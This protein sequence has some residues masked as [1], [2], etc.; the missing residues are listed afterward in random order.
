MSIN[1]KES[2]I[3]SAIGNGTQRF[4]D[5]QRRR[6]IDV[7][8]DPSAAQCFWDRHWNQ[9]A[10]DQ[11]LAEIRSPN[12]MVLRVTQRYLK[13]G[14][15]ILEGGCGLGQ[16]VWGLEKAGYSVWGVDNAIQTLEMVRELEP[17]LKLSYGDV[18]ELDFP[19]ASF[20][21]YWS[22]G[23]IEHFWSGYDQILTEMARVLK[24]GGY[25]FITFPAMNPS[26]IARSARGYYPAWD[27]ET[28]SRLVEHFY[29]FILP[30]K[31]VENVLHTLGFT[32]EVVRYLDGYK[33]AKDEFA[34]VRRASKIA[35]L[36]GIG[37][38]WQK[39][40]NVVASNRYGHIALLV[41]RKE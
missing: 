33:G 28:G 6:L 7:H 39:L 8:R 21:G 4:F 40:M 19:D 34:T 17:G 25:L 32:T 3:I 13:L 27:S 20:D 23:V 5:E 24:P 41:M 11:C 31:E 15:R 30:V 22:L 1:L 12:N 2:P 14:A 38:Y 9:V 16:N 37:R 18:R 26:R 29:Q 36:F 10:G 35:A